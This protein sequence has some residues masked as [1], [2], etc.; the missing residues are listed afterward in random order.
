M[1]DRDGTPPGESID[2]S[3]EVLSDPHR[4]SL[5]RYVMRTETE[6]VT[7][8]E[9][10]EY[11]VERAPETAADD[12]DSTDEHCV[13]TE[14]RHVHLPKLDEAGLVEYDRRSGVV[15]VDRA[16]VADRLERVRA[17]VRDLQNA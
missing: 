2:A 16:T 11:V 5:C 7:N 10:V 9:L 12:G 14:L 17:I 3:F 4:R 13:A 15:R 8:E 1:N 6:V